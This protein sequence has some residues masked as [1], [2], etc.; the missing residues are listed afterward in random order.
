MSDIDLTVDAIAELQNKITTQREVIYNL[1]TMNDELRFL[2]E[3]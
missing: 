3:I 2:K 1:N